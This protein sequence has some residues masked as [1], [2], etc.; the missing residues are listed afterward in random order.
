MQT[1]HRSTPQ[2]VR[3]FLIAGLT[4]LVIL[5]LL[6]PALAL[7]QSPPSAPRNV[8]LA[9]SGD[10]GTALKVTWVAPAST[11]G[12]PVTK[13]E[14]DWWSA[15]DTPNDDE[16]AL[17]TVIP[18]VGK[19]EHEIEDLTPGTFYWVRVRAVNLSGETDV[20]AAGPW[21]AVVSA[22]P[23][24]TPGAPVTPTATVSD[25]SLAVAWIA[26]TE[27][28]GDDISRYTVRY[29]AASSGVWLDSGYRGKAPKTTIADLTNGTAYIVQVQAVNAAGGGAWTDIA[30][31][32]TPSTYPGAPT[33]LVLTPTAGGFELKWDDPADNGGL[34]ISG[35]EYRQRSITAN[36]WTDAAEL[37]EAEDKYTLTELMPGTLYR[38]QVRAKNPSLV[39]PVPADVKQPAGT[40][41]WS[42]TATAT[43]KPSATQLYHQ[44]EGAGVCHIA[45]T[46]HGDGGTAHSGTVAGCTRAPDT[47]AAPLLTNDDQELM[48]AWSVPGDGGAEIID[49][50]VQYRRSNER[51]YMDIIHDG[52]AQTATIT[53]L[54][55]GHSYD[56]RLRAANSVGESD[57]SKHAS[58]SPGPP[59]VVTPQP[60]PTPI[61]IEK[62]VQ[63]PGPATTNTVTRTRTVYRDRSPAP[64]PAPAPAQPAIIGDSGYATTYLA[65]DG[66]SIELRVH[67]QAGGP[68]SHNFALGSYVRDADLGQTYQIV[69]GGKRRWVSP[70]SPLVYAIPWAVVNSQHTYSSLVVAAIPLDESSPPE[71]FL[72]R[73]QNGRIVSYA[74][75]AWRWVPSI[76]TFQ[77]LGYRWCDV[78]NAD[79]GFFSR[80]SEGSP[81][82]ASNQPEDPNYPVCG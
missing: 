53:G 2:P 82:A 64:A 47:P 59:P 8:Q 6:T 54:M 21:S 58:G 81:H 80:I 41:P 70:D 32:V 17:P 74:M 57:W 65:V 67:P 3:T 72:V 33:A 37:A 50:D 79:G 30:A 52:D 5:A 11:G 42:E 69:A 14:L 22:K 76:P 48:V 10:V 62:I 4:A 77:S 13:Y 68:A 28:G 23:Y 66:R 15:G 20:E 75:S 1:V 71:G 63:V 38:V 9:Q 51:V 25:R 78:N 43:V 19:L 39:G 56:V 55:N 45:T 16:P 46:D 27:T 12:L 29:R 31:A 73:G 35:Y 26:P 44:H 7:A 18:V 60:T 36:K 61:V 49:Y 24:R 40:G 34:D